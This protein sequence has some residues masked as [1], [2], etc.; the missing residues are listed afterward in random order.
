MVIQVRDSA[1]SPHCSTTGAVNLH[2][3][4]EGCSLTNTTPAAPIATALNAAQQQ[5]VT[6]TG[7]PMRI[8]AGAGTG[9]TRTLTNR[10]AYLVSHC[11]IQ[12]H[13]I[14]AL[15]FTG[16]AADEMLHRV[17]SQLPGSYRRLWIQTFH[18]LCLRLIVE[19]SREEGKATPRVLADADRL[20][21][22]RSAVQ[23]IADSELAIH[24]GES[25]RRKLARDL[26]TLADRAKDE[27]L[28]PADI[29]EQAHANETIDERLADL[30]LA[31]RV[32]QRELASAG[33][34]DF[35][36]LAMEVVCRLRA[37]DELRER[38]RRRFAHILVD[39]FQD[40][41]RAQFELLR[42]LSPHGANLCVVGDAN[43]AIYA[44]RGGRA[45]FMTEFDR[46]FPGAATFRLTAN[47][48]SHTEILDAANR[49]ISHDSGRED[50][51][52]VSE[53][54]GEG[55]VLTMTE[56]G[57][58]EIEAE[59]IARRIS[60]LI[61]EPERRVD[62][63]DIAILFRSVRTSAEPVIRA[64]N[65]NGIP[66]SLG[67]SAVVDFDA[68]Q[69]VL[70]ALRLV[71]GPA[72]WE[73]AARLAMHRDVSGSARQALERRLPF[74]SDRDV[75]L[76]A[77]VNQPDDVTPHEVDLIDI[78]RTLVAEAEAARHMSL[79][80]LFYSAI[81]LTGRLG[82]ELDPETGRLFRN[83][84]DQASGL[85]ASGASASD[86]LAHLTAGYDRTEDALPDDPGGVQLLTVHAA[87]G[88]EWEVVF[89]T[90]MSETVF[91][92]PMRLDRD[93]DLL[94]LRPRPDWAN[95][96]GGATEAERAAAYRQEERRL[97]YVAIT[98]AQRELHITVPRANPKGPLAP[99]TFVAEMGFEQT[100]APL[101]WG[102]TGPA[103]TVSMLRRQLHA[104]RVQALA[105]RVDDAD[106]T[107]A[108]ASLLLSQ[109]ASAGAIPG[110][111][112][113]RNRTIPAPH[114][115]GTLLRFSFSGLDTYESCPRQYL[116]AAVLRLSDDEVSS[117]G[118]LG[119]AVHKALDQLNLDWQRTGVVPDER[120]ID[121][122]IEAAW[123]LAGFDC[124][125]QRGQL[126]IR[127]RAM[128]QRF[129]A[130]ERARSPSRVPVA[131][132]QSIQA[133]F[134]PHRLTGRIDLVVKSANG[135]AEVVDFKT[136]S[137]SKLKPASSM[138]LFLYGHAWRHR[139]S[140]PDSLSPRTSFAALKHSDDKGFL[141][142]TSWERKQ[143]IG[144]NHDADSIAAF[145]AKVRAL[146]SGILANQFTPL[147]DDDTCRY[148]R[149]RWICPEG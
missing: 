40:T 66:Y 92:V 38:T 140:P 106:A 83:L 55:A 47:Y 17:L 12:P 6:Y 91:P 30:A 82:D 95:P 43:Q 2:S 105:S 9:K 79:A 137:T 77:H 78:V 34:F 37:D 129:Y 104:R 134:G 81:V 74:R 128:I 16:K 96:A 100:Q 11:G 70:A 4:T 144:I 147:P 132:E 102:E 142:G 20:H 149:F 145:G 108:L 117:A 84:M 123:P 3:G 52:L 116:Y 24:T 131:V 118:A 109:W 35:G 39:E 80:Q 111:A 42:L 110:A 60:A 33:A 119:S 7:G 45:A 58:V 115:A 72:Q 15:T 57:N 31:Y 130:N 124:Q 67:S 71:I 28:S 148:C 113:L 141:T 90:G 76:N 122:A 68:V 139:V 112:P 107:D 85:E 48:R 32:Y 126:L 18:S 21:V 146:L 25:G 87:K 62:F 64:L 1:R 125:P 19:W 50:F 53:R 93:F 36:D 120:A 88:L 75:L 99:S 121:A 29:F 133:P 94:H 27:L 73:D 22:A 26:L 51:K 5:A 103:T 63:P 54:L 143:E 10:F 49:L 69:D 61:R 59:L 44:F 135:D 14:L 13:Q 138:Q 65:A 56:A 23:S 97:A 89:L 101:G 86:L 41:N 8:I 127:A 114:D 136:G 98:R 46:Y